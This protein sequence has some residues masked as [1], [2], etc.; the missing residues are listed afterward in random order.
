MLIHCFFS[1][2]TRLSLGQF[3][4]QCWMEEL[5]TQLWDVVTR[6]EQGSVEFGCLVTRFEQG[7]V[8]F[9]CLLRQ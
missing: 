8:K 3:Q 9:E 4:P 6:F 2:S 7:L 5:S 1:F